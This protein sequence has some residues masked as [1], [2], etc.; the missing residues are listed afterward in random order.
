VV[1]LLDKYVDTNHCY[2]DYI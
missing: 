1:Y 2:S